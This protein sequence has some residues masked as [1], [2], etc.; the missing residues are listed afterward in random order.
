M[1]RTCD[2][3]PRRTP[4]GRYLARSLWAQGAKS[5]AL[6]VREVVHDLAIRISGNL[7][8]S[9]R[10]HIDVLMQMIWRTWPQN[11][12]EPATC[13]FVYDLDG[14]FGRSVVGHSDPQ[15]LPVGQFE[16]C[17]IQRQTVSMCA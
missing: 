4:Y 16:R 5:P 1:R 8:Y 15:A 3:S 9:M 11:C 10:L 7:A 14:V 17:D 2:N 6:E 12:R 13:G